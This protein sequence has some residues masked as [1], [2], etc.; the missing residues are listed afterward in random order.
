MPKEMKDT[1]KGGKDRIREL[2]K[3]QQEEMEESEVKEVGKYPKAK[4]DTQQ[5]VPPG[6]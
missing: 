1:E 6:T 4:G 5:D 2:K 3:E